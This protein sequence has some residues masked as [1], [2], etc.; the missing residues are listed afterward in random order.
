MDSTEITKFGNSLYL[1]GSSYLS[2]NNSITLGDNDFTIDG[3]TY[4][5]SSTQKWGRVFEINVSN[6]GNPRFLLAR[7]ENT[8]NLDVCAFNIDQVIDGVFNELF[9]FAFVYVRPK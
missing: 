8:S 3:W 9:H 5:S 4:I 7:K 1:D 2:L 6:Q